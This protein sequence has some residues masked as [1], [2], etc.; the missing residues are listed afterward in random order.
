M[1]KGD[2]HTMWDGEKWVNKV[3]GAMRAS[4][5]GPVKEDVQ[6]KGRQM[7]IDRAVE[8][9]VHKR[10]RNKIQERSTYP[11]SRDPRRSKG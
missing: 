1:A 8:H 9:V 7:A 11:R 2:I 6:L 3:E 10:E 4:N 5:S